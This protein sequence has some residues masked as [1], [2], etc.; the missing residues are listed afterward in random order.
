MIRVKFK[1]AELGINKVIGE[2]VYL[3]SIYPV[4]L[5]RITDVKYAYL[6]VTDTV[7]DEFILTVE[8]LDKGFSNSLSHP[9]EY[10]VRKV[11]S[12]NCYLLE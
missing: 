7:A 6:P 2:Y 3:H 11:N 1:G 8:M 5:G 4:N 12:Q 9:E 10:A